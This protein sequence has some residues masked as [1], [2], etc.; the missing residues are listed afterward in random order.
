MDSYPDKKAALDAISLLGFHDTA[1]FRS[2]LKEVLGEA[3]VPEALISLSAGKLLEDPGKL[4]NYPFPVDRHILV[5]MR[6]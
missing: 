4:K 1:A 6:N 2:Y 5:G 3:A